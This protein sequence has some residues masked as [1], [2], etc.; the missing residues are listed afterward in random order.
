MP[1]IQRQ[2]IKGHKLAPLNGTAIPRVWLF[3]D[4]ET[5]ETLDNEVTYHHFHVGWCCLWRR[6]TENH[7]ESHDWTFFLTAAGMNG[8]IQEM[9]I[10]YK[11]L[12]V[13]GHNIF[14][15]LQASG[16]FAFLTQQKWCLDFYYDKGLTYI[17]KCKRGGASMNLIS[18]TNWFDQSLRKLGKVVGLEKLD[19]NFDKVTPAQLKKYCYRDVEI[20]VAAMKYYI[21]FV[22]DNKLGS[23]ALTKASQAFTAFRHRF[24][25]GSVFI[26]E[27]TEVH[28][29]ERAAYLGGRVECFQIGQCTGGPFIS[30]DVNSMYPFVM[31]AHQ[32]P[33]KL[34][35]VAHSPTFRFI[36]EVLESYGVIAEVEISTNEPVYA[37]RQ[38]GKTIF[39]VGQF[40]TTLCTE[41]L[42][43]AALHGHI[44][45]IQMAAI[46]QMEDIF[47][48]YVNF[49]Y[50]LRNKY[51]RAGNDVMELLSKYM[52][53]ALYGKFA[54]L[55]IQNEKED[56]TG[57]DDYSR[58]IIFNLTT[59]HNMTITRML[60]TQLTQRMEG[61]GKNSNVAIAAHITENA[62]LLLWEIISQ[63]GTDH[64]L[65]CDTDSIKIRRSDLERVKWTRH[66]TRLGALKIEN[67]SDKLYIEGA[68]NYR[69]EKGRR[70]KGIPEAAKEI[71]PGVFSYRWFA[72][73]VTHLEKNIAVG[74]R[75]TNMT[76][77][78]TAKYTK[79]V[80]GKNG[81][82]TPF[83]LS[84]PEKL[85][86][87]PLPDPSS[88]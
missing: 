67:T 37:L 71:A 23:L 11:Y 12:Y 68:K 82:V 56:I 48:K 25:D 57:C 35:R 9:A 30:L 62:R 87:P 45:S 79:G 72:G 24:T 14:F 18:S 83:V 63:I 78:L 46:Y 86:L 65:Y 15:D 4:T 85:Q 34:L 52:L 81:R 27:Q 1:V 22:Q 54:Q 21:S 51:R 50:R 47:T 13:I 36:S 31:K 49:M 75:V 73:Q 2:V 19:V 3:L 26:H 38:K 53:N 5:Q 80:V 17:L 16:T 64:V 6:K 39:P 55:A 66:A 70:I 42:R 84:T 43:Y 28:K 69:T 59:G 58:E 8:Y 20:L 88:S 76:R 60:N 41:G 61:E 33:V 7:P 32:Y 44:Q 10:R 74:A 77:T 29:M 40:T